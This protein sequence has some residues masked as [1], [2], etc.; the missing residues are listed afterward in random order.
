MSPRTL[1]FF[2]DISSPF[3][4]LAATQLDGLAA[5]TGAKVR[6]RPFLLGAVFKATNNAPPAAVPSKAKWLLED[7]KRWAAMYEVP[8]AFPSVFPVNSI[9]TQRALVALG[10][11][12]GEDAIPGP[13]MSLFRAYWAEDQVPTTDEALTKALA[14]HDPAKLLADAETQ[15]VKDALR[16]A[17]DEAIRRGAFG[18]PAFFVGE[19]LYFGNDRFPMIERALRA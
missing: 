9:R 2:F 3:S 10:R 4:Y 1:E 11:A 6:W 12:D 13:A 14:S 8:Y 16:E 5:R 17:T 19:D 7:M 18:A 15:S